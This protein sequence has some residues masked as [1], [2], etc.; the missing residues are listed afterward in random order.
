MKEPTKEQKLDVISRYLKGETLYALARETG[1]ETRKIRQWISLYRKKGEAGLAPKKKLPGF[2][3]GTMLVVFTAVIAFYAFKITENRKEHQIGI[4]AYAVLAETVIK[5]DPPKVVEYETEV[6]E[7]PEPSEQKDQP[8]IDVTRPSVHVDFDA[9]TAINPQVVAW[10]SSADGTI[11]YPVVQ[12]T[13]NE[14][15][16][17]HLIDGTVNRNGSLFM[18]F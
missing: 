10:I 5:I 4:D 7:A 11:N 18:D 1:H 3:L 13:G 2:L 14:Y 15:Y 6:T 12:G 17:D 16:L 8:A 9:L